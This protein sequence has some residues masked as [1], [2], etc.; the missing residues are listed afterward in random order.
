MKLSESFRLLNDEFADDFLDDF[1][2]RVPSVC[3]GG[4]SGVGRLLKSRR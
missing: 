2:D 4:I 1:P 3:S